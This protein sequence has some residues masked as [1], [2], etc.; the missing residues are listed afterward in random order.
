M[1]R[2]LEL[3]HGVHPGIGARLR[4]HP[5]AMAAHFTHSLVVAYAYPAAV[6]ERLLP[7]GLELDRYGDLGFVA[8]AAVQADA[9]RP[10]ILPAALGRN[11]VLVGYR[12]FTRYRRRDGRL[13]RGLHILR[14][15]AN[16]RMLVTAGN[17]LTHYGYHL[18][19]ASMTAEAGRLHVV[20]QSTDGYGDL[21]LVADISSTPAALPIESP[22]EL[23]HHA[24][25]FAGPLPY[26]FD[27]EPES[28]SI[29]IIHG[30]R[31]QWTPI[32][33]S[34]DVRTCSFI[35]DP[36]FGGTMPVLANAFHVADVDYRWERG[37]REQLEP[38]A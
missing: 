34:V 18:S 22:F 32:S 29:V 13:L 12:I 4:R 27:Y 38:V 8:V 5:I 31:T 28:H 24:R 17:L 7:P 20:A 16:N 21:D 26:T 1:A 11:Y 23:P 35:A 37:Q 14:S 3:S 10:A 9:M 36:R 2:T 30:V 19:S 6:L 33:V 25:R 15:D